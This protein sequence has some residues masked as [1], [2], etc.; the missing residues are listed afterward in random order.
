MSLNLK[1]RVALDTE[2]NKLHNPDKIWCVVLEDL[3]SGEVF[4]FHGSTPYEGHVNFQDDLIRFIVEECCVYVGH[5]MIGY[6]AKNL[7]RILNKRT[8]EL[9]PSRGDLIPLK[10]VVDTLVLSRLFRPVMPFEPLKG[11]Y[12]RRNGHSLAAWGTYLGCPK[13]DFHD[14]DKFSNEMLVYCQQDVTLLVR[15]YWELMRESEGFSQECIDLEHFVAFIMSEQ[16]DNGFFLDR[17]KAETLVAQTQ[18]TLDEMLQQIQDIFP[19]EPKLIRNLVLATT[20]TGEVGKVPARIL[21]EYQKS[22]G[23]KAELQEDGS[24]NLYIY[25]EF[26]PASSPQVAKRLMGLGW[27][28]KAF[29]EKGNVK[30]DKETV[31][32]ALEELLSEFPNLEQLRCLSDYNIVADR[33]QKAQKWLLLSEDPNRFVDGKPDGY[34]HG[35]VNP[36]GAGTHR[37]SHYDDNMANIAKVVT[38]KLPLQSLEMYDLDSFKKF[39]VI[40]EDYIYISHSDKNVEVAL[41]GLKGGYGWDSRDC[42]T[43]PDTSKYCVVGADASGIQLRALAHYMNDPEYTKE[44]VSGDIHTRHGKS[45]GIVDKYGNVNRPR[46][47]TFGYAWL[48]GGGDEKIGII[49]GC[50]E[51]EYEELFKIARERKRWGQSQL[52]YFISKIRS[53]GRKAD[54]RTVARHIKGWITKERFLNNIPALK[55]LKTKDIPEATKQGYLVGLDGRKLWI[56]NQHLA[57]SLY[58]Q[59]Y[60]A[61]IIKKALTLWYSDLKEKGIFFKLLATVHDEYQV[62]CKWEDS[63]IVGQAIV[64]AIRKAGEHFNSNC[65]LDGEYK[66]GTSW[67]HSH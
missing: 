60:E 48:L 53:D 49:V 32:E 9:Y 43:V 27:K 20:K 7:N 5:N 55:R 38:A 58:L 1:R 42:W 67:A 47:K 61:V 14:F 11:F 17:P 59:G 30:T 2:M 24:Y 35:K 41:R 29:T 23:R 31:K 44:L 13:I 64:E 3:D 21:A 22:E 56:P 40:N 28:P 10:D 25:Q 52:E 57:M 34:V 36:I 46:S 6:D 33:L 19:P 45:A 50:E 63:E 18:K 54:K 26:N 51:S 62:M 65:P 16:E 39:D 15:I 37:M 4:R 12:D 66:V 8:N